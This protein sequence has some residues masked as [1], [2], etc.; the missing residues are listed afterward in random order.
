[1]LAY[2]DTSV[3][4][5]KLL[6]DKGALKEW[7]GWELCYTSAITRV[8]TLRTLDRLRL[9]GKLTDP[10]VASVVT[11]MGATWEAFGIVGASEAVLSRAA[12]SF[13]TVLGTLDAIHL[14]SALLLQESKDK[15]V[16][17]LTHDRQLGVGARAAGLKS[18]GFAGAD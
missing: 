16:L 12:Q 5:R 8:E 3:I 7:G 4:L 15:P 10:E 2:L 11:A 18:R 1:M 14:A 6:G 17:L 13:P 9:Q